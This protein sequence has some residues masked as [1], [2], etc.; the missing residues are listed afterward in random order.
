[1]IKMDELVNAIQAA[2]VGANSQL[3]DQSKDFL[4]RFFIPVEREGGNDPENDKATPSSDVL[5]PRYVTME[6]PS[7][8]SKGIKTLFVDVPL[9][10]MVPVVSSRIKE[11]TFRSA[12]E[13]SNGDDDTLSISF[14][15]SSTKK[16]GLFSKEHP[17]GH[18]AEV[19]I[20]IT[21]DETPDG[22]Q[23][24]IEGYNRVL[25]AQIPG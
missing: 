6:Y 20:K 2:V 9:I 25:R 7:E 17:T 1:M 12:L 22:L 15:T 21:G 24:L 18:I 5:R 23:R 8:T 14:P 16:S 3:Q 11:V 13:V 19:E 4:D 10:S